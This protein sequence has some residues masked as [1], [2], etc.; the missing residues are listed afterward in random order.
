M[1]N[2]LDIQTLGQRLVDYCHQY[3]IPLEFFFEIIND[4][5]VLPMLRGKG[6]EYLA[7]LLLQQHL[8][9]SEWI[10]QKLNLSPQPGSPDQDIGI[11]HR[12]T[13]RILTAES[14]SAV[15]GS[16]SSGIRARDHK[17][18][19]FKVKC[20]RSRSNI[21]LAGTSNDRY[22]V[23]AFDILLSNPSNALYAGKT[24]GEELELLA[25]PQ[26]IEIAFAHY[27]V[28]TTQELIEAANND[29]RFVFPSEIADQGGFIPR[30]PVVFLA[31]DPH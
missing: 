23:D 11:T 26:L 22:S 2:K 25:D 31:N 20:H 29:W 15:R 19:H 4:Q 28:A 10:I 30:T 27:G 24:I 21:K 3:S 16:M 9:P 1:Q 8:N 13:G 7:F 12:R 6:M 17:I 18:P 5:K 14:K